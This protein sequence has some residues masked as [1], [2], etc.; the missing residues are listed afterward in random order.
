MNDMGENLT[1][2]CP[3]CGTQLMDDNFCMG[4]GVYVDPENGE[5]KGK[6]ASVGY[7]TSSDFGTFGIMN[8]TPDPTGIIG[9]DDNASGIGGNAT[10]AGGAAQATGGAGNAVNPEDPWANPNDP[11]ANTGSSQTSNGYLQGT[12]DKPSMIKS[13]LIM[14]AIAVGVFLL[15]FVADVA[16]RVKDKVTVLSCYDSETG[17]EGTMN[18]LAAGDKIKSIEE[19]ERLNVSGYSEEKIKLVKEY[20]ETQCAAYDAYD[21]ITW[22]IREEGSSIYLTLTYSDLD[23]KENVKALVKLG[24]VDSEGL[25]NNISLRETVNSLKAEGW[26]D[27]P[28]LQIK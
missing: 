15:I 27:T 1:K 11:W 21:C 26:S 22:K 24:I 13:V 23:K 12:S 28:W 25:G 6:D 14:A 8:D 20:L 19:V 4:C 18:I 7:G 5:A 3:K 17:V 10:S 16:T 2:I 9:W